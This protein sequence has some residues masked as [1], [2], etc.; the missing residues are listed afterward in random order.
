MTDINQ[1]QRDLINNCAT[2]VKTKVENT[3]QAIEGKNE[4]V[5]KKAFKE[6]GDSIA[7][8]DGMTGDESAL[9][10]AKKSYSQDVK[11]ALL[12]AMRAGYT[13]NAVENGAFRSAIQMDKFGQIWTIRQ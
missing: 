5:I 4:I 8:L 2:D 10:K 11:N 9:E 1:G 6:L 7:M 12:T 3:L 13:S